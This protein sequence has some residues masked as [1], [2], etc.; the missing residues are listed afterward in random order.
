MTWAYNLVKIVAALI[1]ACFVADPAYGISVCMS[2]DDV[3]LSED[4]NLDI[5]PIPDPPAKPSIIIVS[6]PLQVVSH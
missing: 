3:S 1:L 4:L 5:V 2:A 6:E